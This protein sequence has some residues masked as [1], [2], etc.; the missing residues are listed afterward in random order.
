MVPR[1]RRYFERLVGPRGESQTLQHFAETRRAA[2]AG[3]DGLDVLWD[4]LLVSAH[5]MLVPIEV[6]RSAPAAELRSWIAERINGLDLWS[7][8]GLTEG[9]L[10]RDDLLA[11][12][13]PE[14]MQGISLLTEHADGASE[15]L[16]LQ[17]ALIA[18]VDGSINTGQML[19]GEPPF[20]RRAA[21]IAQAAVVERVLL[22]AGVPLSSLSVW[23]KQAWPRFQAATLC[24]L[25]KEPRWHGYL[26]QPGQ[27]SQE[28]IGRVMNAAGLRRGEIDDSQLGELIFA[29]AKGSLASKWNV[30]FARLPGPLEGGVDFAQAL[31]ELLIE[32]TM[33][34]LDH[35]E[36]PLLE[37]LLVAAHTIGLGSAPALLVDKIAATLRSFDATLADVEEALV[38]Q[39]VIVLAMAASDSRHTSLAKAIEEFVVTRPNLPM[40][41]RLHAGLTAYGAFENESEWIEA[42]VLLARRL[43]ARGLDREEASHVYFV[44]STMCEAQWSLRAPL[45]DALA[46]LQSS[47][48][49][50]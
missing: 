2:R 27:L 16:G 45:G 29:E 39:F 46:R 23:A 9:L 41:V 38:H 20:W 26:L 50:L 32:E 37:R 40:A 4:D 36:T 18:H 14:A 34:A 30:A 44:V 21:S 35:P 48:H 7:L 1:E 49:R 24:D 31:P 10:A 11:E 13:E 8:T 22:S 6:I 17:A 33:R 15:R 12:F 43:T 5:S 3:R 25:V 19:F 28:L 42:V 47:M